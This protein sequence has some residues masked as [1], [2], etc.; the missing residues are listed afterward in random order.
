MPQP[1]D[2]P[3]LPIA[4]ALT[5]SKT[6]E[7]GFIIHDCATLHPD[8]QITPHQPEAG[9][10]EQTV[11]AVAAGDASS[12]GQFLAGGLS[13]ALTLTHPICGPPLTPRQ[14]DL[15]ARLGR[16][17]DY[18]PI[19]QPQ[20]FRA[21]LTPNPAAVLPLRQS[22][23][24]LR[25][26]PA[27]QTDHIAILPVRETEKFCLANRASVSAWLRARKFTIIDPETLLLADLLTR[28]ASASLVLL[29]DPRQAGLLGLCYPGC[30]ILE[31]APDGWL[32]AQARSLSTIF[33][34][35]WSAF[36]ASPPTYP[37]RGALPFGSLVPCS[38]EIPIRD[39][40]RTLNL[41][42]ES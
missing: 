22:A 2:P 3:A 24:R 34:L 6:A 23:D 29:A 27:P 18:I 11:F 28:L 38:Y 9:L 39:L 37:L 19:T 4:P 20:S 16:L 5:G 14:T 15:L 33:G 12:I 40:A 17:R 42:S 10:R 41:L 31:I 8:G 36:I 7:T 13:L 25:V 30:K 1:A 21:V 35:T 32:G 26:A